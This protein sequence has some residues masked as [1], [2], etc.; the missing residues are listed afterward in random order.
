MAGRSALMCAHVPNDI[1]PRHRPL[2]GGKKEIQ[3]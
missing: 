2:Y 1:R 3:S